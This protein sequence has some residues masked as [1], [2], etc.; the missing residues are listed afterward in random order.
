MM[1]ES[2]KDGG[3]QDNLDGIVH[4]EFFEHNELIRSLLVLDEQLQHPV[5]LDQM[6]EE[7]VSSLVDMLKV[8]KNNVQST[9]RAR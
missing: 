4:S 6:G 3:N 1:Q 7:R 2:Q 8:D 5:L 9:K